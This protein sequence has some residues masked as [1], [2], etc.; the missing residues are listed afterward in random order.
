[1]ASVGDN[2]MASPITVATPPTVKKG[3]AGPK[4][5]PK[6]AGECGG[7]NDERFSSTEV[8]LLVEMLSTLGEGSNGI[9]FNWA[10]ITEK[11]DLPSAG[12]TYVFL[13]SL[14]PNG[15]TVP[16][17]SENILADLASPPVPNAP[18]ASSSGST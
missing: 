7:E 5:T 17:I 1:M 11:L 9:K 16:I 12:A 4:N 14:C 15:P 18:S 6:A 10:A 8:R 13:P 2:D 3:R